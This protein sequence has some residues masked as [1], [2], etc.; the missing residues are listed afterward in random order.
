MKPKQKTKIEETNDNW[1]SSMYG[2]TIAESNILN[3]LAL[4]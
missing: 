4:N 2:V 3:L 1:L